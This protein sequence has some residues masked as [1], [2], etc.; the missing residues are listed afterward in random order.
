MDIKEIYDKVTKNK[1]FDNFGY[2]VHFF[3]MLDD[4]FEPTEDWQ[5]GFYN[6]KTKEVESFIAS[7]QVEIVEKSK[8]FR[9]DTKDVQKLDISK[10]KID[11]KKALDI[12]KK[13]QEEKYKG[14]PAKKVIAILQVLDSIPTWN[15]TFITYT[16]STLNIKVNAV[17]GKV[18][19][20]DFGSLLQ[21][22]AK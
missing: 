8:A 11:F 6:K 17:T 7:E 21:W 2:L 1:V 14:Q 22:G 15:I 18:Y 13:F 4:K 10:V 12:A 16:Y 20:H 19:K 5:V 3:V 9:H